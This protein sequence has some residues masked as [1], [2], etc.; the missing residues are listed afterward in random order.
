MNYRAV[1]TAL[2]FLSLCFLSSC[3]LAS[4]GT[5]PAPAP[6]F[7]VSLE[8][9]WILYEDKHFAGASGITPVL[10][11]IAPM[12]ATQQTPMPPSEFHH[13]PQI[14]T[15]AGYQLSYPVIYCVALDSQCAPPGQATP[16]SGG[17]PDALTLPVAFHGG[18]PDPSAQWDWV[19]NRGKNVTLILPMP[20]SISGDGVWPMR[21]GTVVGQHGN[22]EMHSIGLHLHYLKGASGF[23]LLPC[24]NAA[25]SYLTCVYHKGDPTYHLTN[26]GT[27]RVEMKAP[28]NSDNCD[29][30]VRYAYMQAFQIV[31]PKYNYNN[32]IAV[33]DPAADVNNGDINN[34]IPADDG[35]LSKDPQRHTVTAMALNTAGTSLMVSMIP[36]LLNSAL[37][38]IKMLEERHTSEDLQAADK[39]EQSAIDAA[40]DLDLKLPRISQLLRISN[41]VQSSA[42]ALSTFVSRTEHLERDQMLLNQ[43]RQTQLEI[44]YLGPKQG[45]DCRAAVMMVTP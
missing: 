8:G 11:A 28:D 20:D 41:F 37:K 12:A 7:D 27:L 3:K 19:K 9:P 44:E 40:K 5:S 36:D 43:I 39:N 45:N 13:W 38:D 1:T 34:P 29:I 4:R 32:N 25:P 16:G 21:F 14:S 17:Y 23:D 22:Y 42:A 24:D 6:L 15:G 2:L 35:C 33:I 30:H 10:I 31:D 18:G 26:T